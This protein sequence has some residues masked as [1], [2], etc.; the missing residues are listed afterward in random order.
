M[1]FGKTYPKKTGFDIIPDEKIAELYVT[2]GQSLNY[3]NDCVKKFK[4]R[5]TQ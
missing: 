2:P 5:K 4:L 3:L 1:L